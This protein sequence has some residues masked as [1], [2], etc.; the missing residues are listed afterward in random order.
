MMTAK[1]IQEQIDRLELRLI[2]LIYENGRETTHEG[3]TLL[4]SDSYFVLGSL[5]KSTYKLYRRTEGKEKAFLLSA[6]KCFFYLDKGRALQDLGQAFAS[7]GAV[8][9]EGT[10][11]ACAF[12]R[13]CIR[14]PA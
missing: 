7:F 8:R 3:V 13:G 9:N 10:K 6:L 4:K 1:K 14:M 5:V 2:S 12:T 11:R